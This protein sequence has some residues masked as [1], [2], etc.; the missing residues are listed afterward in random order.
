MDLKFRLDW[1]WE[2]NADPIEPTLDGMTATFTCP[3]CKHRVDAP[4]HP[5][6]IDYEEVAETYKRNY[7]EVFRK[8]DQM[9]KDIDVMHPDNPIA[10]YIQNEWKA[11]LGDFESKF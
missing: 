2:T 3:R 11:I 9:I 10:H 4:V 7:R 5:D 1:E 8:L 6:Y